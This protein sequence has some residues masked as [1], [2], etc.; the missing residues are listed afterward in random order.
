MD[1][2]L[3][4]VVV[5]VLALCQNFPSRAS[6]PR[7][8]LGPACPPLP[9]QQRRVLDHQHSSKPRAWVLVGVVLKL[10]VDHMY[11]LVSKKDSENSICG[12]GCP[13]RSD[14]HVSAPNRQ[15]PW[16]GNAPYPFRAASTKVMRSTTPKCK[17]VFLL[18]NGSCN[19]S[20]LE[21]WEH[22]QTNPPQI[23]T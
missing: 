14:H 5:L 3:V 1:K 16:D 4:L 19:L 15:Q 11:I 10:V 9:P 21:V 6:P 7:Y 22:R 23:S 8:W 20:I 2:T 13:T 17:M 18:Q 12:R